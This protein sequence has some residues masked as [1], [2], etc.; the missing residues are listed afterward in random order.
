MPD[1]ALPYNTSQLQMRG[2]R[3][4]FDTLLTAVNVASSIESPTPQ[5]RNDSVVSHLDAQVASTELQPQPSPYWIS[6]HSFLETSSHDKEHYELPRLS[7]MGLGIAPS[8]HLPVEGMSQPMP[9][10]GQP[11]LRSKIDPNLAMPQDMAEMNTSTASN[12]NT[13]S[14]ESRK[15]GR[16]GTRTSGISQKELK[17]LLDAPSGPERKRVKGLGN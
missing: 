6:G 8:E 5:G 11:V 12:A 17:G 15:R 4:S 7:S 1:D 13:V 14:N 2:A 10:G 3:R 16:R 9:Y